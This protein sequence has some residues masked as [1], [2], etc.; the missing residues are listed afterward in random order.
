MEILK[1]GQYQPLPVE[2]QILIIFAGTKAT[3]TICRWS[4]AASSKRSCTA[5]WRMRTA[6]LLDEI[7]DK[8]A[9][10]DDLKRQGEGGD[11][12]VQGALRRRRT[13]AANATCL[14]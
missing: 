12:G 5:S 11:R 13:P 10:D 8:K 2:K 4:S 14:A 9:L 1:Q 3:W 6:P 7:R